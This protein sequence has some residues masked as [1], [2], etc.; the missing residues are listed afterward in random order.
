M[1]RS[2]APLALSVLV[3][4]LVLAPPRAARAQALADTVFAWS[5]YGAASRCRARLYPSG[6]EARPHTLVVEELAASRGRTTL[7]DAGLLAEL[8]GRALG[9][10]PAAATWVF[11]WGAFSFAGTEARPRKDVYLRATFR[12]AKSGTLGTP[13]WRV[14]TRAEVEALTDRRWT[15]R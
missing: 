12:R 1:P 6:E 14:V 4:L 9:V 3:V 11:H 7:D 5:G 8:L 2:L 13:A 10:D 15:R